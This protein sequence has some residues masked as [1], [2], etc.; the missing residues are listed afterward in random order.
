[1]KKQ[2]IMDY[3]ERTKHHLDAYAK[4]PTHLDWEKQPDLFRR[5]SK[6]KRFPLPLS[7]DN[8]STEYNKLYQADP[9]ESKPL[10]VENIGALLELSLGI[11]AWKQYGGNRWPLRCN[12]SSGN[13]HPTEAYVLLPHIEEIPSGIYHYLS[14]DHVLEQRGLFESNLHDKNHFLVG[15]SSILWREAW[16][17]GER[18]FRYCQH[19]VG[20]AVAAIEY[21]AASLG[22]R[23]RL[24]DDWSEAVLKEALG[25]DRNQLPEREVAEAVLCIHTQPLEPDFCEFLHDIPQTEWLGIPNILDPN[26]YYAW[27]IVET[28]CTATVK[29]VSVRV[30]KQQMK[31]E[32]PELPELPTTDC[33]AR[34]ADIIRWRRS[35]QA[36][37]GQSLLSLDKFYRIIDATLPRQDR[38][39]W[40]V[41]PYKPAIHLVL[42]VHRVNGLAPGV[43]LLSRSDDML[44]E[45]K[46]ALDSRFNWQKPDNCPGH[47]AFY[48]LL[49]SD[50]Q[51][52]AR[53]ISCHQDIAS[54]GAFSLAMLAEFDERLDKGAWYYRR[55]FWEAGVLGQV[56]YLEAEAA[57]ISGTGIGCYFDDMM[58]EFLG[59]SDKR[60]QSLYHFTVGTAIP[61]SRIETLPPYADLKR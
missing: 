41:F 31:W 24:M 61:D 7:A 44:D 6:T 36:F 2:V 51:E 52:L 56:L 60:F 17:Y 4:G 43:Y 20:H 33:Y 57:G 22:W 50:T 58:H 30:A 15:I 16:K 53:H 38:I 11:S 28:A 46:G 35:A 45:L 21:A 39:P 48:Q 9:V 34:A 49:E 13:L 47:L 19:D 10:N 29:P 14:V 37:D 26:H 40:D 59:L 23:A 55:L 3:H 5:Y 54:D 12:P 42:F 18:A 8:L 32:P 25:L 1:M 27:P